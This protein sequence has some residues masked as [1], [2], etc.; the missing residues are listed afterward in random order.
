MNKNKTAHNGESL[1]NLDTGMNSAMNLSNLDKNVEKNIFTDLSDLDINMEHNIYIDP[2]KLNTN[3]LLSNEKKTKKK[4]N[5]YRDVI[6]SVKRHQS[7][8]KYGIKFTLC[9]QCAIQNKLGI[10]FE[11]ED[12]NNEYYNIFLEKREIF[13]TKDNM[14]CLMPTLFENNFENKKQ[15][16]CAACY[17]WGKTFN[18]SH[19]IAKII[20]CII[21][22][23][24]NKNGM[25]ILPHDNYKS[26]INLASLVKNIE[27]Y[28]KGRCHIYEHCPHSSYGCN[29][30]RG[31]I[32]HDIGFCPLHPSNLY[33][34]CIICSDTC[35]HDGENCPRNR[36]IYPEWKDWESYSINEMITR[37]PYTFIK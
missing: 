11:C 7:D 32:R 21:C 23:Q 19:N 27:L 3:V 24:Y 9:S 17:V 4:K 31:K 6:R 10:I 15:N 29:I 34:K 20:E 35:I 37:L 18:C 30:C 8:I 22:K 2:S 5:I 26:N 14:E 16:D 33:R 36:Y 12:K 13:H 1:L 25:L 28:T